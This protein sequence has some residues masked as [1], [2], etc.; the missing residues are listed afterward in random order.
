M[1]N[2]ATLATL[3]GGVLPRSGG[4]DFLA[5]TMISALLPNA[6][7]LDRGQYRDF[8]AGT[9]TEATLVGF[10]PDILGERMILN[11]L[12]SPSGVDGVIRKLLTAA[13]Q[14]QPNDLCDFILR[15]ADDFPGDQEIVTLCDLP[16]ESADAR[17]RWG[18]LVGDLIRVVNRSDDPGTGKLLKELEALALAFPGEMN[19]QMTLARAELHLGNVFFF[20][21]RDYGRASARYDDA[22]RHGAGTPIEASVINNRG[23][24]N[25]HLRNEDEAF[26]DW[27]AV[28]A[29]DAAPDEARACSFNNRADVFAAR[30]LHLDAIRDSIGGPCS[31]SRPLLTGDTLLSFGE[32]SHTKNWG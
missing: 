31:Q 5:Q 15:V 32:A 7:L 27:S 8:V 1:E 21:E 2:L 6:D 3:V 13:W 20:A 23:I 19:L 18:S 4:F 11:R 16:R 12:K 9:S 17:F 30:D 28:I 10:Q 26:A 22:I 29:N 14:I 24:L 25:L